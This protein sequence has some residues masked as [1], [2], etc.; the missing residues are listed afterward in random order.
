MQQQELFYQKINLIREGLAQSKL[1]IATLTLEE[2]NIQ[3]Y[4]R[5]IDEIQKLMESEL[6]KTAPSVSDLLAL[7]KNVVDMFPS[8]EIES[9]NQTVDLYKLKEKITDEMMSTKEKLASVTQ[10]L[11][12]AKKTYQTYQASL[13]KQEGHIVN[14]LEKLEKL[15]SLPKGTL[16]NKIT[17]DNFDQVYPLRGL[18]KL[19]NEENKTYQAILDNPELARESLIQALQEASGPGFIAG[20]FRFFRNLL[21]IPNHS[22]VIHNLAEFFSNPKHY[23]NY[24]NSI[25]L[26][27]ERSFGSY[28]NIMQAIQNDTNPQGQPEKTIKATEEESPHLVWNLKSSIETG[29]KPEL[30]EEKKEGITP[31]SK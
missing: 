8:F 22:D 16:T 4:M 3:A 5:K 10:E 1:T 6:N 29:Q 23:D 28:Q 31:K 24:A 19:V 17:A 9:F 15:T 20:N 25:I 30:N 7:Q 27:E 2:K 18:F 21:G 12:A 11:T 14:Y 13:K 26:K